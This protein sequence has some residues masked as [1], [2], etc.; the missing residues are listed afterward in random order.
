MQRLALLTV[1]LLLGLRGVTVEATGAPQQPEAVETY[2]VVVN[3][4]NPSKET[5]DA[6]KKTVKALFLKELTRWSDGVEAKPYDRDAKAPEHS[7]FLQE[8]LGMTPAELARHWLRVKNMSGTTPPME[9]DTDR[10]LLKHVER[11]DG[12]FGVVKA[13]NATA[14]GVRV[15][16]EFKVAR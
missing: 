15:L 12:A 7:A 6:A 4:N 8:V 16:F 13:A 10:L 2:A 9:V 11:N 1:A 5:G 14:S 3:A